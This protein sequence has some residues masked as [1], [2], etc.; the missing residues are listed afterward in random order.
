MK[1]LLAT[2]LAIF[3]LLTSAHGQVVVYRH[4]LVLS[5]AFPGSMIRRVESGW[6]LFDP[7]T[8]Q[9]ATLSVD[10]R[11][12]QFSVQFSPTSQFIEH[13]QNRSFA[14]TTIQQGAFGGLKTKGL[15]RTFNFS[16]GV[17]VTTPKVLQV[18][19]GNAAS[20]FYGNLIFDDLATQNNLGLTPAE[21]LQ[22]FR[23]ALLWL[24]YTEQ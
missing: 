3:T 16:P 8:S 17:S 4:H 9:V 2:G 23:A 22:N 21:G 10:K 15:N 12:R 14:I 20:R 24:G 6:T 13:V 1:G 19:G 5:P 18:S 11:L 7:T